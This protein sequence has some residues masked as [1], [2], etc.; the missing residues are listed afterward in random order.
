MRTYV[1]YYC[2]SFESYRS[3]DYKE[4]TV[5]ASTYDIASKRFFSFLRDLDCDYI[6]YVSYYSLVSDDN[7]RK[8]R[9]FKD[10]D[11]VYLAN[12][13]DKHNASFYDYIIRGSE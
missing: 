4:F 7:C 12:L 2:D 8:H 10:S 1:F 11:L 9:S 13:K 3:F 5:S 6:A